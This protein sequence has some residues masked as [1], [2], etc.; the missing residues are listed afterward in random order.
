MWRCALIFVTRGQTKSK[1]VTEQRETKKSDVSIIGKLE[2]T[3][4]MLVRK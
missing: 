1:T 3:E 4:I 2:Y